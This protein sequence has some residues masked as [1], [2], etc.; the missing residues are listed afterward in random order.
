MFSMYNKIPKINKKL[1]VRIKELEIGL[2]NQIV[3]E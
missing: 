1:E 2:K 3:E